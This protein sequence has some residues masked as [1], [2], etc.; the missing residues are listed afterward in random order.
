MGLIGYGALGRRVAELARSFAMRVL[1]AERKGVREMR[2]GRTA[3]EEVLA[4]SDVLALLCP[5]SDETRGLIGAVEL[6][7][8]P[9]GALLINC[10]RGGIVDEAALAAALVEGTIGGA[11]VD[12]LAEEPP[13]QSSPLLTLRLPTLIVTPHTAWASVESLEN[14]AEQLIGNI[15]AYV[16]GEGRNMVSGP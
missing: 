5:L 4:R 16:A 14:L 3:F 15:E 9:R 12:V 10:A 11:G 1:I 8:M 6:A 7:R 2:E 13:R